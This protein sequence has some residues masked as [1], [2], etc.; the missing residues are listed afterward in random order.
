MVELSFVVG[1]SKREGKKKSQSATWKVETGYQEEEMSL[2]G[3][4]C[5]ARGHPEGVWISHSFVFDGTARE[6]G[7]TPV[8]VRKC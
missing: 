2:E 7:D 8:N 5:G 1:K 3:Y 4:C 6:G